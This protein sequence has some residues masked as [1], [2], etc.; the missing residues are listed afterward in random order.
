FESCLFG[1]ITMIKVNKLFLAIILL[2]VENSYCFR[3]YDRP[4]PVN[5]TTLQVTVT[6]SLIDLNS[7]RLLDMD[8]RLDYNIMY[9]WTVAKNVCDIYVKQLFAHNLIVG[10]VKA[11]EVLVLGGDDTNM[12]WIPDMY[13]EEAKNIE[14]PT[15]PGN[16]AFLTLTI[17]PEFTCDLKYESRLAALIGCQMDFHDY[18]YDRQLCYVRMRSH[19]YPLPMV[20]YIWN[21]SGVP[22]HFYLHLNDY[23]ISFSWNSY[24][25][26]AKGANFSCLEVDFVFQRKLSHFIVQVILPTLIIVAISYSSFWISVDTG[27]CRFILTVTTLLSLVTQF[28]GLKSQLPPVSYITG[29]DIW[30]LACMCCVFAA[31]IEVAIANYYEKKRKIIIEQRKREYEGKRKMYKFMRA[32]SKEAPSYISHKL[33]SLDMLKTNF[34]RECA[35]KNFNDDHLLNVRFDSSE[36]PPSD[37]A[38]KLDIEFRLDHFLTYEW[39]VGKDSCSDYLKKITKSNGTDTLFIDDSYVIRGES[40]KHIWIPDIYVPEAKKMELTTAIGHNSL[41]LLFVDS[42]GTC[43]LKHE[44]R[45]AT[46][47][48]CQMDFRDYPYDKQICPFRLR[49]HYYPTNTLMIKWSEKGVTAA[50]EIKLNNYRFS[51]VFKS[52]NRT[53]LIVDDEFSCLEVDFIFERQLSHFIVQVVCPSIIITTVAYASFWVGVETGASRFQMTVI[54]LLSLITQFVGVKANLPPVSYVSCVDIWMLACM[55]FVFSAAIELAAVNFLFKRRNRIIEK[56]KREIERR[57]N[58][59]QNLSQSDEFKAENAFKSGNNR[60]FLVESGNVKQLV[61]WHNNN[62][63]AIPTINENLDLPDLALRVD[64]VFRVIYPIAFLIFNAVFWPLLLNRSMLKNN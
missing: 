62:L 6:L 14:V 58:I 1:S 37:I 15:L 17:T 59:L 61:A 60:P 50:R 33:Q 23:D 34:E 3:K 27:P 38:L 31:I 7:I 26:I 4:T 63:I 25:T 2:V 36:E 19:F 29:L 41:L 30:M 16:N 51:F 39:S 57:K 43:R 56:R 54:T 21:S 18:P 11:G 13:I 8:Y 52:Y 42:S 46:I 44:T 55:L 28:A 49:N 45:V 9:E 64:Q 47:V 32:Q 35:C 48:S 24:N 22:F 5:D 20:N 12:F 53:P 40:R 10:E